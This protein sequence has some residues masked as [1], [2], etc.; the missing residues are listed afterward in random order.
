[1]NSSW[2]LKGILE[3]EYTAPDDWKVHEWEMLDDLGFK[4]DGNFKMS[5][6]HEESL[7]GKDRKIEMEVSRKKDGWILERSVDG[8]KQPEEKFKQHSKLMGRLHEV[9]SNF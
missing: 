6:E 8:V 9:F 7:Y 4:I 5:F 3:S 1:M 2:N